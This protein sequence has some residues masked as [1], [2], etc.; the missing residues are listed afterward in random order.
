MEGGSHTSKGDIELIYT[1]LIEKFLPVEPLSG[2]AVSEKGK[3]TGHIKSLH[4]WWAQRPLVACRAAIFASLVPDPDS[5]D[6]PASF[7]SLVNQSL[8]PA[9]GGKPDT[10][11]E[12]LIQFLI[13]FC[14][15]ENSNNQDMV[16]KAR[17]LVLEAN[18]GIPPRVLDP[19]AGGGAIPLEALRVGCQSHSMELNPVAQLIDICTLVYPQLYGSKIKVSERVGGVLVDAERNRLANDVREWGNWILDE[20]KSEIGSH[21]PTSPDESVPIAYLWCR[22][23]RC[24]DPQC[25]AMIPLIGRLWLSNRRRIALRLC[26]NH[27]R[28]DWGVQIAEGD[29]IDFDPSRG[30]VRGGTALCPF[31]G[32][33]LRSKDLQ[34]AGKEGKIGQRLM[35]VVERKPGKRRKAYRIAS[36]DDRAAYEAA[37]R[38][39]QAKMEDFSGRLSPVPDEP[40]VEWSGV[41]NPP[42]YGLDRW[43]KWF[44]ARQQLVMLTIWDK[45][46]Q[47][48]Q[49]MVA[50]GFEAE[51]AK[52]VTTYLALTATNMAQYL[53]N[54]SIW[55]SEGMISVFIQGTGI[56]MRWDYA[57]ANPFGDL[58]GSW[59][60]ALKQTVSAISFASEAS[61]APCRVRQGTATRLPFR[62][63]EFS[64][65]ITDPP[66]YNQIPYSDLSNFF[67]VW[68][69]RIVGYLHPDLFATRL[70][71]N[72]V[73][74]VQ[75]P[76]RHGGDNR[77]AKQ[78]YEE[79]LTAALREV[80]RVLR[81]D[82]V[83][84]VMFAHKGTAAWESLLRSLLAAG[85]SVTASWPLHTERPA[86]MRAK[87]SAA[88]ASSFILVCRKRGSGSVAEWKRV[89]AALEQRVQER[90]DLFL[91]EGIRGADVLISAIGPAMEVFGKHERVEKISGERVTVGEFLDKVHEAVANHAL[92]TVLRGQELG[93]IDPPTAFYVLYRW[94]YEA[95]P[96][97]NES[98]QGRE[99]RNAKGG[100]LKVPFDDARKLAQA[101]GTE[102]DELMKKGNILSKQKKY[103]RLLAPDDRKDVRGLGERDREGRHAPI[104]DML[105]R[106]ALLWA[107]QDRLGVQEY[108][109]TSGAAHNEAFWRVAQA[110]SNIL[111]LQSREKRLLDGLLGKREALGGLE[112]R[113]GP[114][115]LEM[116]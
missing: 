94:T 89:Q 15:W 95:R 75:N 114:E 29:S 10:P 26:L 9:R 116:F 102:I 8:P 34:R 78:F 56:A 58:V 55:L 32:G 74:I 112:R 40:A 50:N 46:A 57:E 70:A 20:A 12:R 33:V 115:Q 61:D 85:L 23:V 91:R 105:H 93:K 69:K 99:S 38:L 21:Y 72:R 92:Q 24:G 14:T 28:K 104:I 11:R 42:I 49:A 108:L 60:Y 106:A 59:N 1:R 18:G 84:V 107:A 2:E 39:L 6:C 67:Y 17:Q 98:A 4:I 52:A 3:R 77:K 27:A 16:Q 30:T 110:L 37:G 83:T 35:A 43:G 71:P 65:V 73:E 53:S 79:K 111:P 96:A 31:C 81:D 41:I 80:T 64:A 36:E 66:Y 5:P 100:R 22:T 87:G 45:V 88:L 109:A 113:E 76:L 25:N 103:V 7:R 97:N 63:N 51:Y 62:D 86:R 47:V 68:L 90:L 19:F 13:D 48:H 101:V 82:G 44:N 54:I